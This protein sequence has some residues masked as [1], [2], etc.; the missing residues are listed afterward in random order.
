MSQLKSFSDSVLKV[1]IH[2][3]YGRMRGLVPIETDADAGELV[4]ILASLGVA[5]SQEKAG[6]ILALAAAS[7]R[8][9]GAGKGAS[10]SAQK[11]DQMRGEILAEMGLKSTRGV[12]L[13]PPTYQT[14]MH[15]FGRTWA[16][17]MKE[18]GLA[19]TTD[20]KVGR[21]NARFSEADRIRAIR[22][23]LAECE[24]TQTAAS[25][26]GYAK[27]AKENGQPS[28]SN[29]RQVY[30]TWNQALEQL[31]RRENA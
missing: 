12:R 22:A 29:I 14:I 19:A 18:C 3:A 5:D 8:R 20:G 28:G 1:A 10:L 2:Y 31:E 16:A 11:Y 9:V 24:S 23:Y 21:N 7:M 4:A 26:A 15:R 6:Q 25:Y 17:A 30:G 27:W 13:W